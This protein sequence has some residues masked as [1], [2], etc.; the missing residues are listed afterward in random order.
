MCDTNSLTRSRAYIPGGFN[1]AGEAGAFCCNTDLCN[2][3]TGALTA[4]EYGESKGAR[5]AALGVSAVVVAAAVVM[6][7][8]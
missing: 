8:W 3:L 1:G 6:A 4:T 2:Q 7:G 5:S